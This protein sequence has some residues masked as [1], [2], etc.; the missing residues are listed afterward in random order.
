MVPFLNQER[1]ERCNR[2]ATN[3][4]RLA[5]LLVSAGQTPVYGRTPRQL[6]RAGF[7]AGSFH[8]IPGG[9]DAVVFATRPEHA[10][11]TVAACAELGIKHV[12]THRGP[13]PGS[14]SP[15]AA[16]YGRA[17]GITV[18]DGGRPLMFDPTADVAHKC[19]KAVFTVTRK[20]PQ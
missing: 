18:T 11:A 1:V 8:W 19:M 7:R 17:H 13:G 10:L 2:P 12:W 6:I 20:I 16:T 4:S 3:Q 15:S 9:V 14:V 5:R